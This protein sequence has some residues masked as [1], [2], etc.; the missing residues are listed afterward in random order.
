MSRKEK[1]A[2]EYA[3]DNASN[4]FTKFVLLKGF[5]AGYAACEQDAMGLVEALEDLILQ[6]K[7]LKNNWCGMWFDCTNQECKRPYAKGGNWTVSLGEDELGPC[8]IC[9]SKE[10]LAKWKERGE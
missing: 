5:L 4:G 9:R 1:L 2:A 10:V 8:H 6:D 3:D 7:G